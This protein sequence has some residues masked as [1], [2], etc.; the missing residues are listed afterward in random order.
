[1]VFDL[2]ILNLFYESNKLTVFE[3][4][5]AFNFSGAEVGLSDDSIFAVGQFQ[6]TDIRDAVLREINSRDVQDERYGLTTGYQGGRS[7]PFSCPNLKA[8][9]NSHRVCLFFNHT[10]SGVEGGGR[11]LD[12]A[13]FALSCAINCLIFSASRAS[14]WCLRKSSSSSAA[15]A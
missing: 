13:A 8:H 4:F 9:P 3:I 14:F 15:S 5:S 6:N 10:S 11:Y 2:D 1:M 7:V 12:P